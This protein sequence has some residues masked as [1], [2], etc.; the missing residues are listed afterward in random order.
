M[1]VKMWLTSA[2]FLLLAGGFQTSALAM[3]RGGGGRG[4]VTSFR[5]EFRPAYRYGYPGRVFVGP[6][7]GFG[8]GWGDPWYWDPYYYP[9]PNVVEVHRVT[10]GTVEFKVKP[11]STKVYVDRKFIGTVDELDHHRAYVPAG[12]HDIKLVAPDG[13]TLDRNLYVAAGQKIKIE[14]KL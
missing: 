12:N 2:A 4:F 10:Y 3:P 1:R 9:G 13:Q 5:G 8:W 14:R 7:F 6:A 11:E